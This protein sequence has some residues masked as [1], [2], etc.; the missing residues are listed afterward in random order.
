M[1]TLVSTDAVSKR[2]KDVTAL[3]RV[4]LVVPRGSVYGLVGPNGA[5]KTTML[6]IL[7]G[8]RKPTAG[9]I[10]VGA[11]SIEVLPDTPKF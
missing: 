5:G 11:S 7:A 8:L 6:G 10:R 3:D 4:D 9:S 2:Y 1:E